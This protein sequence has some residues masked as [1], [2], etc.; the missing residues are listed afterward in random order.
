MNT[1]HKEAVFAQIK[2]LVARRYA[3][4]SRAERGQYM[5]RLKRNVLGIAHDPTKLARAHAVFAGML[6]EEAGAHELHDPAN[7]G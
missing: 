2:A 7:S 5:A 6:G 3:T 1:I 4:S